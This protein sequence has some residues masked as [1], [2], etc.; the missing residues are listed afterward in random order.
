MPSSTHR[1]APPH[2]QVASDMLL[3]SARNGGSLAGMM[4]WNGAH[5]DT[6]RHW[7]DVRMP[8]AC[9]CSCS[10][11][12]HRQGCAPSPP[13][14]LPVSVTVNTF[15]HHPQ[16]DWDGYNVPLDRPAFTQAGSAL[17]S[18]SVLPASVVTRDQAQLMTPNNW[19]VE[20]VG[21]C[22]S[23]AELG[24]CVAVPRIAPWPA[25]QGMLQPRLKR[26]L[27]NTLLRATTKPHPQDAAHSGRHCVQ[28]QRRPARPG[29]TDE[30]RAPGS[31]TPPACDCH[32]HSSAAGPHTAAARRPACCCGLCWR[33]HPPCWTCG[34]SGPRDSSC[35]GTRCCQC[36][37]GSD[38]ASAASGHRPAAV[39][40]DSG[41]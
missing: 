6:V 10:D 21:G 29:S 7:R 22:Q 38:S 39:S 4:F 35:G 3:D 5:N 32:G 40:P 8:C 28:Q 24:L 33:R 19:W 41:C 11:A 12:W 30:C 16:V 27:L 2:Y 14:A 9:V 31:H 36:H 25:W 1:L 37:P 17:P 20:W 13:R 18:P 23:G 26:L 15:Q 34:T